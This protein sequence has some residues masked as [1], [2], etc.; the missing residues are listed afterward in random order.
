MLSHHF[1]KVSFLRLKRSILVG[2]FLA[3]E[4]LF[5]GVDASKIWRLPNICPRRSF[6]WR[7]SDKDQ[8]GE[9]NHQPWE[10]SRALTRLFYII[11][12]Q[13]K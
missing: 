8:S 10:D 12:Q 11:N 4:S 3:D 6:L 13:Q 2:H 7:W 1:V 5:S 9:Q